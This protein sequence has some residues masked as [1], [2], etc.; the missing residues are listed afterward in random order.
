MARDWGVTMATWQHTNM[1]T[2]LVDRLPGRA[3][4]APA[5]GGAG[6]GLA[7]LAVDGVGRTAGHYAAGE[8][9]ES[10]PESRS[11]S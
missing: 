10:R 6:G 2:W 3:Q 8:R 1:V 5:G 7:V 11:E 9:S 4:E